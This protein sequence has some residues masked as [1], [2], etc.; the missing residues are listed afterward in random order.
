[1]CHLLSDCKAGQLRRKIFVRPAAGCRFRIQ[2]C[3][4]DCDWP[5]MTGGLCDVLFSI[6]VACCHVSLPIKFAFA[7]HAG[8]NRY[9]K[10]I[11]G[12]QVIPGVQDHTS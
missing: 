3:R 6:F 10:F 5:D 9:F 12:Y 4:H 1:M 8:A 7:T 11:T 2:A